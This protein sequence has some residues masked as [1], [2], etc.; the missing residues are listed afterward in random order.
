ML[1]LKEDH[2]PH[3]M[4]HILF[5]S[6]LHAVVE[7]EMLIVALTQQRIHFFL[8]DPEQ[9]KPFKTKKHYMV[10]S[11]TCKQEWIIC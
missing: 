2:T 11:K 1:E 8:S 6:K 4:D 7:A 10:S 9:T 3:H 5:G